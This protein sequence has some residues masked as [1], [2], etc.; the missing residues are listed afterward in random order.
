MDISTTLVIA[1]RNKGKTAEIR[2]LLD[3]YPITI[4]DLDDFG[5]IPEVIEDGETFEEN[6][7]KK[8]SFTARVLGYPAL[9]DDSGLMVEALDGAPGVQSARFAGAAASNEDRCRKL[10]DALKDQRNRRARFACVLSLAVP[11]GVALTYEGFCEGEITQAPH[12]SNG[13]GYDPLF[14]YPP[15]GKTFAQLTMAEK[16]QV[17]HRGKALR[18]LAAEFDKVLIWIRQHL[19]QG[20]PSTSSHTVYPK[21]R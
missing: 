11:G 9:A 5:P 2:D 8:A 13:F 17:S 15:L 7:F 3:E 10:L 4:K 16:S 6:A 20:G 18:E 1:T 14:Y 21:G 12:G 19:P